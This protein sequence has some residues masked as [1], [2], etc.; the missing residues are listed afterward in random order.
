VTAG[1]LAL[2]GGTE[3]LPGNEPQDE[4][5]VQAARRLGAERPAFVI[6]TA[7]V[8]QDP[9][10]AV[11]TARGWFG[12]LGLELEELPL[13]TRGAARSSAIAEAAATGRFFYLCGGDPG[14]V[15]A[16]LR[17][18][19]AWDAVVAAWRRGAVLAGS[20]AGAMALGAW[21]LIRAR[22]P[23]DARRQPRDGLGIVPRVAVLPHYSDFGHRWLDS[24]TAALATERAI[25]LG[26]D[27]RTATVWEDGTWRAMGTGSV[28]VFEGGRERRFEHGERI[29]GLPRPGIG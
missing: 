21:T 18:T 13:R 4:V 11:A 26:I 27:A 17:D 6:A 16:T 1:P 9:D 8:R 14:I 10:R 3:F 28:V 2:V 24:A 22:M 23:G 5:M 15:R 25:L 19:P 12:R 20:S 7:A 29:R